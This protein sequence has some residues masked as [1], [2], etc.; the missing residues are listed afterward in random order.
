MKVSGKDVG[1]LW[2]TTKNQLGVIHE[3]ILVKHFYYTDWSYG[4]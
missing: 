2:E 1:G 3:I 4:E